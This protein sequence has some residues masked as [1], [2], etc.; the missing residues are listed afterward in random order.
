MKT[1]STKQG[2]TKIAKAHYRHESGSQVSKCNQGWQVIGSAN[3]GYV[4]GTMWAAM[5]AAA[6]TN[7]E[8]VKPN[9]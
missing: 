2:W 3:C 5:Y 4:Y 9:F 7:A 8:F 6:K 1:Q